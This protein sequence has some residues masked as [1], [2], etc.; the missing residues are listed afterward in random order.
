MSLNVN[1]HMVSIST[2]WSCDLQ[3]VIILNEHM[4]PLVLL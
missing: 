2:S 4:V 3:G 1:D